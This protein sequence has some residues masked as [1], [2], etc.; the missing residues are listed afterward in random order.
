[1]ERGEKKRGG[2]SGPEFWMAPLGPSASPDEEPLVA[3][4]DVKDQPL[5]CIRQLRLVSVQGGKGTP[6]ASSAGC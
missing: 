6:V 4:D 3:L 1:M 2:T 5:I